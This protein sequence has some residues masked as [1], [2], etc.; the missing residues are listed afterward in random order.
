[1]RTLAPTL[2]EG[3]R[4]AH[5]LKTLTQW[6]WVS[7]AI[8]LMGMLLFSF[9]GI[10][11]NHASEIEAKPVVTTRHARVPVQLLAGALTDQQ[12]NAPL[13]PDLSRWLHEELGIDAEGREAEWSR[14]EIYLAMPRPGGDAWLRIA[15]ATGE[16]EHESTDRGWL[17]FAND[18]HKGRHTGVAWRWFIDVFAAACLVFSV[19]GLLILK[20]RASKRAATWPVVGLGAVVPLLLVIVFIH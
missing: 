13:T 19:S 7:S 16:L 15:R 3:Q 4:R 17:A 5:W 9:T 12:R 11:L 6:H 8:C 2:T 14:D 10:T 18:L 1:M 20:L